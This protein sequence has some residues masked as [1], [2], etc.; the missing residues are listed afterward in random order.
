[1]KQVVVLLHGL[2]LILLLV[3]IL[4]LLLPMQ[5]A[6]RAEV[7]TKGSTSPLLSLAP[8]QLDRISFHNEGDAFHLINHG[9]YFTMEGWEQISLRS[10][11]M[12]A[13]LQL[14]ESFPAGEEWKEKCNHSDG[15]QSV[16]ITP[17]SGPEIEL[18]LFHSEEG[19]HVDYNGACNIYPKETIQALL[20]KQEQ[21]CQL[22]ITDEL[23]F[24]EG[25]ILLS[26]AL[27]PQALSLSFY[28]E[29]GRLYGQLLS[30][31]EIEVS[32]ATLTPLLDSLKNLEAEEII[33]LSPNENELHAVG[34]SAPF[35][36]I[37]FD[38]YQK[39][40]VLRC[41]ALQ[42]DGFVYF[43]KNEE[44]IVYRI[45]G[46]KLP[47]LSVCYESLAETSLFPSRYQDTTKMKIQSDEEQFLF[48]KWDG[49][50][51]CRNRLIDEQDFYDLYSI[52]TDLIPVQAALLRPNSEPCLSLT[53]SYTDP[54]E[55]SDHIDFYPYKEDCCYLSINGEIRFLCSSEKVQEILSAC[56]QLCD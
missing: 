10:E 9:T 8:E 51:L 41:S 35:C 15:L 31:E 29:E 28:I 14:L 50:V 21:W 6:A 33:F 44:A 46:A 19:V 32:S 4:S 13:L 48:T 47:W 55:S 3:C 2:C 22:Q 18:E 23:S 37:F 30:P 7:K 43:M 52:A 49:Q 54:T 12:E 1:M 26:G 17:I 34:L 53:F 20:W 36:S 40:F 38:S 5:P 56:H 39:S 16:I 11:R 27:H 24:T 42:E 45:D 25:S